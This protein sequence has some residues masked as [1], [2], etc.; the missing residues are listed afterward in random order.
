M[1]GR[2]YA[3]TAW[4]YRQ[5]GWAGVIPV[6]YGRRKKNPPMKGYTGW[7]G[8]DPS[9]ADIE[10]WVHG[11]EGDWNIG[12]HLPHGIVVPDV[13]AYNGGAATL[14]R[15]E[16]EVG[17]P[18][19]ATWTSTAR[20]QRDPSRHRFYRAV[21]P[22]GRV[23]HDHP[24]GRGSGIDSLH[25]GHRYAV[26]WPSVHP[27]LG[28]LY[29]WYD[30]DG[31]LWED[32]PEPGDFT[33]LDPAWVEI[34]SKPGEPMEGIAA[35]DA[36]T[37]ETIRGFR[38][39]DDGQKACYRVRKAF[40]AEW[41]RIQGARDRETA[42]GL[43][44]P[45]ALHHLVALG[46]EGHLGVRA[47]LARHQAAYTAAR[48]EYRGD[49]EGAAGADWWRQVRGSVGKWLHEFG[50]TTPECD[51]GKPTQTTTDHLAENPDRTPQTT[52]TDIPP[53]TTSENGVSEEG[54]FDLEVPPDPDGLD[55]LSPEE[56]KAQLWAEKLK[57][58]VDDLRLLDEAKEHY[59]GLK[60][61]RTWTPPVDYGTLTDE[62]QLPDDEERWRFKGMLG[63]GHNALIVAGRK[64]G[65]TTMVGNVIRSYADGVPFL[66]RFD[67]E[68]PH[69]GEHAGI[70]VFNYEVDE[71]QYRRWLRD[72]D[73]INTDRVHVL[74]LRG[75]TLPLKNDRVRAWVTR[76]LADRHIGM[77]VVDPYSRAYVGSVDN[78]NDEAQVGAF[79]DTLD[80]IKQDAG[81]SELVMPVHTPKARA[82]AGEETAIG[83]QRL[84]GW[85]DAMWYLTKELDTGSRF[86]RA[87]G[88][89]VLLPEEQLTYH[90]GDRELILNG[91]GNRAEARRGADVRAVTDHIAAHP[92]CTANDIRGA[93]KWGRERITEA[94]KAAGNTIRTEQGRNRAT[95]HYL[96][97]GS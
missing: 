72:V 59:S 13:D 4:K 38:R 27:D 49:S 16:A 44:E 8:M 58:K 73:I 80:V 76:W 52:S 11:P 74:H 71:R 48:V 7:A 40:H 34:L 97:S 33:E 96:N 86:L 42:G 5:A 35:D 21:L 91:G 22:E 89:D 56:I 77:W 90:E 75:R 79:L 88:R 19:P 69:G 1:L 26:V 37:L 62:L 39:A 51:C 64:A 46:L 15:L 67:V 84:E 50:Q 31:D 85:P 54:V 60:H 25:I 43:H 68:P 93:L 36:T 45:G 23:W 10:T 18:L 94:M 92:G 95:H 87:E 24:G 65:K 17:H 30:P 70:A 66:G 28:E 9:G 81:V 47:A 53:Q 6:G 41:E 29:H 61:A 14:A 83:S 63:V 57:R 3:E 2:P 20:G 78:G 32:V 82:E 55:P 12:L